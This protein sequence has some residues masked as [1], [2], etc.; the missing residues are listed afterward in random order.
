MAWPTTKPEL[1]PPLRS[2]EFYLD[3]VLVLEL[4]DLGFTLVEGMSVTYIDFQGEEATHRIGNIYV[5]LREERTGSPPSGPG[6]LYVTM[7]VK[8]E[9]QP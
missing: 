1:N 5:V 8:V 9:L 4:D 3:E 7:T 2:I 6:D